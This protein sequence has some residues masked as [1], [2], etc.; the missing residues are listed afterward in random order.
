MRRAMTTALLESND[1]TIPK[2]GLNVVPRV[3]PHYID[4]TLYIGNHK[5]LDAAISKI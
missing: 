4:H 2:D 3:G 1:H 5:G